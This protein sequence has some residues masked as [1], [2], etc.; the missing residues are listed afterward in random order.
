MAEHCSGCGNPV[1]PD[2]K[3]CGTCGGPLVPGV[4]PQTPPDDV[5]G[6]ATPSPRPP[7]PA[8]PAA[9]WRRYGLPAMGLVGVVLIAVLVV[10][11]T[12]G[13]EEAPV[14]DESSTT[15]TSVAVSEETTT[16]SL[17]VPWVE[18]TLLETIT[19][20][21]APRTFTFDLPDSYDRVLCTS[22]EPDHSDGSAKYGGA[23][24]WMEVNGF[25]VYEWTESADGDVA[26]IDHLLGETVFGEA[27]A[28]EWHDI[29]GL[30]EPGGNEL[31]FF[32]SAEGPG[33]G[34]KVAVEAGGAQVGSTIPGGLGTGDVQVTL[35]WSSVADLDLHVVDPW[36]EEVCFD[37][38]VSSSGGELVV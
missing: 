17:S 32:H 20:A 4:V 10:V 28:G 36:G 27:G 5:P 16:T 31:V 23:A 14:A 18:V 22:Y 11:L 3:F 29:T 1:D 25:L 34:I 6:V 21:E 26:Y 38:P 9:S 7:K 13:G 19:A 35:L 2:A 15:A 12:S 8:G 30:V 37:N 24:A 33:F